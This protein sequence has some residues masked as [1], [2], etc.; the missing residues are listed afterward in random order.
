[1]PPGE[2]PVLLLPDRSTFQARAERLSALAGGHA[3]ADYLRFLAALASAQH[4]AMS[5]FGEVPLPGPE[6]IERCREHGMPTLGTMGWKRDPAWREALC[7]ILTKLE[8]GALPDATRA[9]IAQLKDTD[10]PSLERL[11]ER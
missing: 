11:A 6:E 8:A 2:I 5:V 9:T 3:L 4:E 7:G 1:G 10:D